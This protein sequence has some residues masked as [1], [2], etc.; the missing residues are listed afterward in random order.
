VIK[1]DGRVAP[2]DLKLGM[3]SMLARSKDKGANG[4]VQ[5]WSGGA[6]TP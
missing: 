2:R 1:R 5:M 3:S 4:S 6:I